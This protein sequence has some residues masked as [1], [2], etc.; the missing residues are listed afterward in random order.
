MDGTTWLSAKGAPVRAARFA[1]IGMWAPAA[2]EFADFQYA[3]SQGADLVVNGD[4]CLGAFPRMTYY[5]ADDRKDLLV[6]LADGTALVY[7]N[8][9]TDSAPVFAGGAPILYGPAGAKKPL[10]VGYRA[11]LDLVDWDNDSRQDLVAGAMDGRVRLYANQGSAGEPDLLDP[12]ILLQGDSELRVPGDRSSPVLADLDGDG[13]KDLLTGNTEGQILLYINQGTDAAPLFADYMHV[14]AD[15]VQIDLPGSPRS[16]PSVTDWT[17]DGLPDV[18]VGS[19][20]GIVR[21][22]QSVAAPTPVQLQAG[23]ANRDLEFNQLDLFQVLRAGKYLTGMPATWGEG[24][25]NGA[26]G[27]TPDA[28]PAGDGLFDRVDIIAA[29][30]AGLWLTGPYAAL[31]DGDPRQHNPLDSPLLAVPEPASWMLITIGWL[32]LLAAR[33]PTSAACL[34]PWSAL[35]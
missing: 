2:P 19:G 17:G 21:L 7:L 34:S 10:D 15:G 5:D 20:D 35:H 33:K 4:G 13:R 11:T 6:G 30:E 24:D 27:G 8:T 29:L 12:Q 14:T 9:G 16:R 3:T 18:L 32:A 23:D 25:W 26:P 1:C 31:A 22:Y 28:P